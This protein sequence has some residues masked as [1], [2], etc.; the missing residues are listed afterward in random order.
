LQNEIKRLVAC[1]NQ[2]VIGEE[3]LAGDVREPEGEQRPS[4]RE[5]TSLK[6]AV[7]ELERRMIVEMLNATGNNQQKAAKALGLSRQGL[8]NKMKRYRLSPKKVLSSGEKHF[9]GAIS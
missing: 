6:G 9:S 1:A 4:T 2:R 5:P 7:G 8:I 3:D